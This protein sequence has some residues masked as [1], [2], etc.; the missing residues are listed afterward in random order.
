MNK[1]II[2]IA[3]AAAMAAPVAMA[4]V[5]ISGRVGMH[6]TT[7]DTDG[8]GDA[9]LGLGDQGHGRLQ[10]DASAGDAFA[11]MA[12]DTRK[13]KSMTQRDQYLGYK[14]GNGMKAQFG[15]MG[16]AAKNIEK[17]PYIATFL[18][19]RNTV[20]ESVTDKKFGSSSFVDH[21]AQ[22]SFKAGAAKIKVQYDIGSNSKDYNLGASSN[23]GH[24]AISATGKAGAIN[25]WASYNNSFADGNNSSNTTSE[26]NIKLGGAMKFGK[27]KV[28]LNYT[29]MDTDAAAAAAGTATDS[30]LVMADMGLGNGLSANAAIATRSGDVAADDAQYLRL[31]VNK[32]LSKGVSAYAGY[33]STDYDT[34]SAKPDT[35]EVGVGMTVKF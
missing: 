15:R 5:K 32:K 35:S 2:A 9:E 21:L 12:W 34:A 13:S 23:E 33:T 31:A 16:G 27:V 30:I 22:L 17:D 4:D 14:F 10:L 11:R 1:K 20:A 7:I 25:Y 29:S 24:L 18:Q 26:S 8:A 6:L 3:I 28:S 19:T